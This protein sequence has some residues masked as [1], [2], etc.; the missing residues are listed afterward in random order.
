MKITVIIN[1][2][3]KKLE[4]QANDLL[5][6]VLR[7]EGYK[8]VKKGCGHGE[9]GSCVVIIN[10]KAV[11]SCLVFAA[12]LDKAK[13]T[14]IEGLGNANE[15]HILQKEFVKAGAVQCGYCTPGF[16][17][18]AKALLD[19]NPVPTDDQIKH[20]LD[21]NLCRCTGYVKPLKA[22]RNTVKILRG[23]KNEE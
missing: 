4:V 1:D 17:L 9:C 16:I 22:V 19:E 5:M 23:D 13:I 6:N 18:S 12:R 8:G 10:G 3:E 14:T 21:G 7:R 2:E 11:N 15:P 20:A